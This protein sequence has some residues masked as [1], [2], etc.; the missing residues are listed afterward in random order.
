M[1]RIK[2]VA[3][4]LSTRSIAADVDD[5]RPLLE[6]LPPE[7]NPPMPP[8]S[9]YTTIH[10]PNYHIAILH[11]PLVNACPTQYLRHWLSLSTD[12]V[13]TPLINELNIEH[14]HSRIFQ[15]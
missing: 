2:E 13:P 11:W 5:D 8:P 6:G 14:E 15:V 12:S 3:E 9:E 4:D 1:R 10:T 7:E